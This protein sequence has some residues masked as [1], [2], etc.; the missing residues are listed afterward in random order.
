[1][2]ADGFTPDTLLRLESAYIHCKYCGKDSPTVVEYKTGMIT[3]VTSLMM[4]MSG[5]TLGCF[6]IPCCMDSCKDVVHRCS[7]CR[8]IVGEYHRI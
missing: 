1:M 2:I 3:Y 7:T 4:F 5:C 6:L 8:Q